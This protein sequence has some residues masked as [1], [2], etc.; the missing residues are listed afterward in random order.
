MVGSNYMNEKAKQTE[1]LTP[2]ETKVIQ[3]T[4][5]KKICK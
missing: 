5:F 4:D 2:E 3:G 1:K